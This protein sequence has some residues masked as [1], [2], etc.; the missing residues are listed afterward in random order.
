MSDVIFGI[1][2]NAL[3]E[4]HESMVMK[5]GNQFITQF[6][7]VG[8]FFAYNNILPM[9]KRV[10]KYRM[11]EE[12]T[13]K[14]FQGLVK[15]SLAAR[16]QGTTRNDFFQ[17]LVKLKETKGINIHTMTGHAMTF[18]LNGYDTSS[19]AMASALQEVK[20]EFDQ[21]QDITIKPSLLSVGPSSM[22]TG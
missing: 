2:A 19:I 11:L 9:L 12:N 8:N 21:D 10:Y 18:Y 22:G 16:E 13:S 17:Y 6:Q 14:F 5:M 7:K 1:N 20:R 3:T 15:S 4:E